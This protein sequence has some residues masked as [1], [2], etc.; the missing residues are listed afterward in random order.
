MKQKRLTFSVYNNI[1]DLFNDKQ[2]RV[3]TSIISLTIDKPELIKTERSFV[4][5]H[6]FMTD[7]FN[8]NNPSLICAYWN[9]FDDMTAQWSKQGCNVSSV[10]QQRV[11]CVCD[12]LTHFAVVTV[13]K[14]NFIL[15]FSNNQVNFQGYSTN[16]NS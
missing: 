6:F 4:K 5:I 13:C 16:I 10:S 8:E 7:N 1:N 2:Y 11:T 3:L 15:F 9:I 14:R 12:H